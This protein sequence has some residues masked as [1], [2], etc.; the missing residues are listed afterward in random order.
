MIKSYFAPPRTNQHNT[1]THA[2]CIVRHDMCTAKRIPFSSFFRM[3]LLHTVL[4]FVH[5]VFLLQFPVS[6]NLSLLH[7]R[8]WCHDTCVPVSPRVPPTPILF[9]SDVNGI[10]TVLQSLRAMFVQFTSIFSLTH[11][12][13]AQRESVWFCLIIPW[14]LFVC[15]S[16]IHGN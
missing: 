13:N 4:A 5:L 8:R 7:K 14:S 16:S 10:S 15:F 1:R 12:V 3:L 2:R 11:C 6:L 9:S